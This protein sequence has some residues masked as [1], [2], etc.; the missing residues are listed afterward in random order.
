MSGLLEV[1][2]LS[3]AF[4][5]VIAVNDVTLSVEEGTLTGLIGPN[6]AGKSTL[7]DAVT[8][9]NNA[10]GDVRFAGSS[11]RSLA[12]HRRAEAGLART[13][14]SLELFEDLTVTE[15]LLVAAQRPKWSTV[16]RDMTLPRVPADLHERIQRVLALLG[17]EERANT[18]V[19]DLSLG[20]RKLVT[21]GRALA[22]RPR[23]VLLD[24]PAAGL[25]VNDSEVLAGRLRR[26]V[27]AG[28]TVV[29]VDHDMGLVMGVCD[30]V[31]VLDFGRLIASGSPAEIQ[32]NP[33]VIQAYLGEEA[34]EAV[35]GS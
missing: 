5:A 6:G 24:E 14:Q 20:D 30:V 16:L 31:H 21:V 12:P 15:N 28:I 33:T 10:R 11:I 32:A 27:D 9:F 8:G 19:E 26:V 4:G 29:L 34:I 23:M 13:F 7:I 3:V 35:Q 2:K 18:P 17:L 1:E 22:G 25:D